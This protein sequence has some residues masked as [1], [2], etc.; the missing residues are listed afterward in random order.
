MI[1]KIKKYEEIIDAIQNDK[2]MMTE[3]IKIYETAREEAELKIDRTFKDWQE[4]VS[5]Y[6][7]K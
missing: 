5:E 3:K 4:N 1:D 2:H 6:K 7:E